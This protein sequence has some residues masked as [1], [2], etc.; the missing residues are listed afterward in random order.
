MFAEEIKLIKNKKYE[1]AVTKLQPLSSSNNEEIKARANYLLGYIN[2]QWDYNKKNNKLAA[3]YLYNNLNSP[4]PQPF[5]YV[6]YADV[7][8]DAN[9]AINYLNKG[10]QRFPEEPRSIQN[11]FNIVWIKMLLWIQCKN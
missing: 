9:I 1:V 3:H 4:Y 6:L 5:A 11:Y 7:V 8:K 10:I 2:T